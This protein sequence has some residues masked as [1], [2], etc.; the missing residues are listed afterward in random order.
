MTTPGTVPAALRAAATTYADR[1]ALVDGST[2]LRFTQLHDAVRATA[3]G[4]LALGL[5]P[6]DTVCV[7]A[8]NSWEWVVAG[9]AVS[10]AGGVLVP[11][12]TRYKG[13]EVA[14]VVER[15]RARLCV[16]ADGFLGRSQ[17]DELRAAAAARGTGGDAL[18]GLDRVAAVVSIGATTAEGTTA[19]ASLGDLGAAV[20]DIDAVAAAVRPD[21]IA[22]I[23]FTSGTTGRSKGVLTTH[24]QTLAAARVWTRTCRVTEADRYLVISPFFH[25]YGYKV[26]IV[27]SL[28]S[29][30]ALHPMAAFDAEEAL[31]MIERD[32]LTI[33]PGAPTIFHSLL[34]S[35]AFATTDTSSLRLANTGSASIPPRL[36][37]R[38]LG[39]LSFELVITAFGMTECVVATM[40]RPG[41]PDEVVTT[42]NGRAVEG[43]E[44]RVVDPATGEVREAGT[45]GEIQ[46]RGP[47]VMQGYLDDPVA[48][49][50]AIEPDGWLHTGDLGTV[51]AD[52][53]MRITDRL[54]D[55]YVCGGFNVYPAEVEAA[56]A[57]L[58]GV[59]EAA[60]VGVPDER[61]G[62]VG[63]AFVV[64]RADSDLT[65]EQVVAFL[66]ERIANFKVPRH[67][68]LVPELPRNA[69]HKVLKPE[70]RARATTKDA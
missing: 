8:P 37:E 40:A 20:E 56:L 12:N 66:R 2:T 67:V 47:M 55:M 38:M 23:L 28:V 70:L 17:V 26:G 5:E 21:D 57:R 46:L 45:A 69:A 1:V 24:E 43:L 42:T 44:M 52:G 54:K 48:T 27:A 41:D 18:P 31:A 4:Y 63:A 58:D 62:E 33:V 3:R 49:A 9:L 6:G 68:E 19:L 11:V 64:R 51:D 32:R 35:P 53:N 39:E 22:D 60:V 14:D 7:W 10:Y 15:S 13:E 34:E 30:C 59:V 16:V 29:G 36:V 61:M 25:S 50:E 65:G